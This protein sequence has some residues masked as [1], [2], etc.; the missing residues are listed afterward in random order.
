MH[1]SSR[2]CDLQSFEENVVMITALVQFCLPEAISLEDA[3]RRFEGSAPKYQNLPGLIRKYYIRS[4]DGRVAGG[5][6]LWETRQAA[7]RVYDGEWRARVEKLYGSA[8]TITWFDSPVVVDNAIGGA[9]TK[10]A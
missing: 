1:A 7:E 2:Y 5:I 9:V 10:A 8:P 4:E 6:Y 3:T